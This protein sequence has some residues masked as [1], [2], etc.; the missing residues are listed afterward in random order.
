L[1]GERV[2][3]KKI[4]VIFESLDY[5]ISASPDSSYIALYDDIITDGVDTA[6]ANAV[7][8]EPTD[9]MDGMEE[10]GTNSEAEA[11]NVSEDDEISEAEAAEDGE[12]TKEETAANDVILAGEAEDTEITME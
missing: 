9:V 11:A 3:F 4:D 6:A 12:N 1:Q 8:T 5:V 7:I 2:S 10:D